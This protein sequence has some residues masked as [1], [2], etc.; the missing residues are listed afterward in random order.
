MSEENVQIVLGGYEAY[1][2]G[3]VEQVFASFDPGIVWE[4]LEN[5]PD[6]DYNKGHEAVAGLWASWADTFDDFWAKPGPELVADGDRVV[7][8]HRTGGRLKA[9]AQ[10]A[11]EIG[12]D[13]WTVYTVRDGLVVAVK[14]Y[15]TLREALD[16][17]GIDEPT[18][19][20][21]RDTEVVGV[22]RYPDRDE[23]VEAVGPR[24]H[25]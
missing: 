4:T 25:G 14:E 20:A 2:R 15:L 11:P 21:L 3:D 7:V 1:A 12:Y 22:T 19:Y 23:A 13:N 9:S 18:V 16:A 8:E 10:D 24:Q 17:A 5:T 6:P